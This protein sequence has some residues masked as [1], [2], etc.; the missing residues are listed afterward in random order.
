MKTDRE[1]L[2]YVSGWPESC[3]RWK[4]DTKTVELAETDEKCATAKEDLEST[5]DALSADE[6]FLMDLKEKCALGG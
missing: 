6:K 1:P 2:F 3:G 5:K 4:V